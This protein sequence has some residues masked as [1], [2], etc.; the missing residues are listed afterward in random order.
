M[1]KSLLSAPKRLQRMLLRLQTFDLEVTYRKGI[2]MHMAD[3]LSQA[4]L[5]L[6]KQEEDTKEDVWGVADERSPTEIET[7]Y[8]NMAEFVPIQQTTLCDIKSETEL[9]AD[10]SALATM[11]KQG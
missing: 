7:E 8:V 10:L 11:I 1:K 4:Y 3:P 5:P 6:V 2:E 9:D